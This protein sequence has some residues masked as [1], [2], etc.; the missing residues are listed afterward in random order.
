M[1]RAEHAPVTRVVRAHGKEFV[2]VVEGRQLTLRPLRL[3]K[4]GPAEVVVPWSVIYDRAL[5]ARVVPL[6]KRAR[7]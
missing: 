7:R 4:G 1:T 2:A 3:R 5:M 6:K